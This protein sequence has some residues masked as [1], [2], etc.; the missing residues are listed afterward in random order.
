M[1]RIR[2]SRWW[3]V[4]VFYHPLV[5]SDNFLS[6]SEVAGACTMGCCITKEHRESL[7]PSEDWRTTGAQRRQRPRPRLRPRGRGESEVEV[8][9]VAEAETKVEAE[10]A[11]GVL[12]AAELVEH[13][14]PGLGCA[15]EPR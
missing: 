9:A 1:S 2:D 14:G 13:S 10:A 11:A 12:T 5:P 4:L 7:P 8:E 15:E 3:R 6:S